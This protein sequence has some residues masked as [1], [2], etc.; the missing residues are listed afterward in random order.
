MCDTNPPFA[1]CFSAFYSPK[2][3]RPRPAIGVL[4]P[5][6]PR[7]LIRVRIQRGPI[8]CTLISVTET[9]LKCEREPRR[10]ENTAK[11][12]IPRQE[13]RQVRRESGRRTKLAGAGIGAAVGAGIGVA[14]G[15]KDVNTRSEGAVVGTLGGILIGL[16]VG[17]IISDR[18]RIVYER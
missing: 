17:S 2:T 10:F 9:E 7:A 8:R 15:S 6:F 13:I 4:S 11:Y 14:A 18:G 1:P 5:P 12:V 3:C 16:I